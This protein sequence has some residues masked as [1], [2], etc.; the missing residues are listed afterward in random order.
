M[1]EKC[2]NF[3]FCLICFISLI[4]IFTHNS[5]IMSTIKSAI[6]LFFTRVFPSLFPMFILN[7]LL[8]SLNVPHLFYHLFHN[9]FPLIFRT[10][11]ISSYVFIMC[12]L[13]GTPS[14][15]YI[16]TNLVSQNYLTP[17]EAN[18]YLYFTYFSNPLFLL[19]MLSLIFPFS[20]TLKIILIHYFS[21]III[22]FLI[23]F[24]AP[25]ISTNTLKPLKSNLS[26]TLTKS[27]S[28]SINTLLIILGTI[29]FYM[30]LTYIITNIF[31]LNS[32]I[33]TLIAGFFEITNGLNLLTTNP[34][35]LKL[36]EIIAILIIS[37]SGLSIHTQIKSIL[38]DTSLNYSNYF[39]GRLMQTMISLFFIIII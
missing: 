2:L 33:K 3:T 25:P 15:A 13:S 19:A 1:K 24:K 34:V 31:P 36:K 21:N 29:V 20:T 23:R 6:D 14:Q 26:S 38:E 37:F 5:A 9:F 27:I 11:G 18:H 28:K 35:S 17:E 7:D 12:L 32:T 22:A 39:K 10:S 30:L 8:I 16:L 4:F